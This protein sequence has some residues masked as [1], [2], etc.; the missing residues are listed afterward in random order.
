M[1]TSLSTSSLS[2]S[3]VL[4]PVGSSS[5]AAQSKNASH[6]LLGS[7]VFEVP[8]PAAMVRILAAVYDGPVENTEAPS[9]RR[10]CVCVVP[11]AGLGAC[12]I[13]LANCTLDARA[14]LPR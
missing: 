10:G 5:A 7:D 11:R 14:V 9:S 2:A 4:A 6:L 8:T 12:F 1:C 13:S 3:G